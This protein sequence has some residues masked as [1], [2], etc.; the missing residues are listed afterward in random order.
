MMGA[1]EMRQ[2]AEEEGDHLIA[3]G[4]YSL[5]QRQRPSVGMGTMLQNNYAFSNIVVKFCETIMCPTCTHSSIQSI[6][7]CR[8]WRFLAVLRSFFHSSLLCT[9]SCHPSPPTILPSS[10][11]SSCHIYFLVY[12]SILSFPN[13]YIIPFWEFHF[14]PFSVRAQTNVIC[15]IILCLLQ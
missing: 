11:T 6:G 15:L 9:F 14:L 5:V 3:G 13:S 10:L 8:M 4:I 12:L 2:K 1:A 7:I